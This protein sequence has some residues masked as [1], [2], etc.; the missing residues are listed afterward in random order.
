MPQSR[1]PKFHKITTN[2]MAEGQTCETTLAPPTLRQL[3]DACTQEMIR[4]HNS[5]YYI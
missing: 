1:A 4:Q 2:S 3:N 5:S